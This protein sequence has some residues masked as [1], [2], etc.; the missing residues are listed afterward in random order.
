MIRSIHDVK[1]IHTSGEDFRFKAEIDFDGKELV[2]KYLK[3]VESQSLLSGV[4]KIEGSTEVEN[5][6]VQHGSHMIDFLGAEIDRIERFIL[7][8]YPKLLHLDLEVL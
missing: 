5:F 2:R 8:R 7:S 3:S 1:A 6:L 4:K